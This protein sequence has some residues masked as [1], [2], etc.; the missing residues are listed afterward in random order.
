MVT[1]T[2]NERKAL[3]INPSTR[4]IIV[5]KSERVF[6]VYKELGVERKTFLCPKL[7]GGNLDL[8]E[9]Y[10]F[11]HYISSSGSY[12]MILCTDIAP[13][14]DNTCI[15]F[16]WLLTENVFD[17]NKDATIYFSVHAK[18]MD[19]DG[20]LREVFKTRIAQGKSYETIDSTNE[21]VGKHADIIAQMLYKLE[22]LEK[23]STGEEFQESVEAA[24]AAML[25]ETPL[26]KRIKTNETLKVTDKGELAV[27]TA[28]QVEADNTRPVTAAAVQVQIG[29]INALLETI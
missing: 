4:E 10:I 7:I 23:G 15:T 5:P 21:I 16:S 20:R 28:D 2:A 29:N 22:K 17:E 25:E 24:F 26:E 8:S 19:E 12:G 14:Q 13:T 18:V 9:C 11:V 6:G 27:N 1:V 3:T